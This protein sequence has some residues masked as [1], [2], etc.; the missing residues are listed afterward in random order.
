MQMLP[1][2]AGDVLAT[3]ADVTRLE[4]AAQN[5]DHQM[6]KTVRTGEGKRGGAR[7][8]NPDRHGRR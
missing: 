3:S 2:Q 8:R 6:S 5:H 1:M 7:Q 4:R